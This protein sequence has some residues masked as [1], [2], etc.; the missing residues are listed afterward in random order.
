MVFLYTAD[1]LQKDVLKTMRHKHKG[2]Q[3]GK[4][5]AKQVESMCKVCQTSYKYA[6]QA[7]NLQKN[8]IPLKVY[9]S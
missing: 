6:N 9:I 4:K 2:Y 1:D 7:E 5:L 8:N 3:K